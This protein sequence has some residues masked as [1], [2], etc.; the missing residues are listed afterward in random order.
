[1]SRGLVSVNQLAS[2]GQN[3]RCQSHADSSIFLPYMFNNLLRKQIPHQDPN[4][5]SK[6]FPYSANKDSFSYFTLYVIWVFFNW[7]GG[8]TFEFA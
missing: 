7:E 6:V 4:E 2:F 8:E 3:M 5:G 1:M